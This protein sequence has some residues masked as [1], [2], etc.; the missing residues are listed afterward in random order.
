MLRRRRG[1]VQSIGG[2]KNC[3]RQPWGI[4]VAGFVGSVADIASF[5]TASVP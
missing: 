5:S 1:E 2:D 4:P 3:S